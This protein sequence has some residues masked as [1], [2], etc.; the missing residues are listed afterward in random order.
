MIK[1]FFGCAKDGHKQHLFQ[2]YD[3]SFNVYKSVANNNSNE[4]ALLMDQVLNTTF[5]IV[6]KI[7]Q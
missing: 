7:C 5:L 3:F 2:Q 4:Q 1:I 6:L